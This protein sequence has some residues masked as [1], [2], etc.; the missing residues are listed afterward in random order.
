MPPHVP[1]PARIGPVSYQAYEKE[2]PMT[3]SDF[4]N[5]AWSDHASNAEAV[6]DR[7]NDAVTLLERNDQIPLLANLATHVLGEHLGRWDEGVSF[8]QR[9]HEHKCFEQGES[10]KA[11][12][13]SIAA[14]RLSSGNEAVVDSFS[15]SDQIRILAV[16]AA[17]L[18]AQKQADRAQK[19][20][21]QALEKAQ[22]GI[23]KDDPA[24]RSLAVT[25]NN[26]A[27]A[28]EETAERSAAEMQMMILAA[29]TGRKYWEIAGTWKEV[30]WAEYRLAMTYLKANDLR[31]AME[32]AQTAIEIANE[33]KAGPLEL[34]F[35]YEALALVEK[36]RGNPIGFAKSVD[37]AREFFNQLSA[38]DQKWCEDILLKLSK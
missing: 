8:L 26:L 9:L 22:L 31:K 36:A 14:L 11:L 17:A 12:S 19:Y 38:E 35:N 4:L 37:H 34:F 24:N 30:L 29:E 28:L 25:G 13:R 15:F 27:C 23:P 6:A 3:F 18:S 32:H 20:F 10:E 1:F 16:A 2:I 21:R 5:Q 33:N 7:L